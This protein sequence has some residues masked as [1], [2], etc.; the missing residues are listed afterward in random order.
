M[1]LIIGLSAL[2]DDITLSSLKYEKKTPSTK[3]PL[4][5]NDLN[6]NKIWE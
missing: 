6:F 1:L 2:I 3:I 4:I 5:V